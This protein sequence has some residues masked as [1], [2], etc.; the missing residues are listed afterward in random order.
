VSGIQQESAVS[1]IL[2]KIVAVKHEEVAAS[3]RQKSL[4]EVERDAFSRVMTRDFVAAMR[5]K[6]DAGGAAVIAEVKKASPSKGVLR[7]DFIAADIAQSYAE[8]G[9]A[10]LSVLTDRQFFQGSADYL[11]QAR[12]SCDL[13]V[14]RKDFMVDAY[15]VYESRAMGA[16]CILLIAA[17]LDDAQMRELEALALS[18][19]M[20]VLV[21]VHDGIELERALSLKTPLLGINNRNLKTF[22]VDLQTTLGLLERVPADRLLVTESGIASAADVQRMRGAGVHA[23]LVGEAF[24]RA[25]EPGQALAQLFG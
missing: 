10:C 9:A 16:D 24:M 18:L 7:S 14:L 13:P 15:Q 2:D 4:A 5:R 19:G 20:A 21:E 11:K 25:P 22:E 1:D 3:K 6:I 17:C 12:A 23:F 8:H